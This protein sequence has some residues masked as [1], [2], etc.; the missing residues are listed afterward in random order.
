MESARILDGWCT[1]IGYHVAHGVWWARDERSALLGGGWGVGC[2]RSGAVRLASFPRY[3]DAHVVPDIEA[4]HLDASDHVLGIDAR[5][6]RLL[7]TKRKALQEAPAIITFI[8]RQ[9]PAGFVESDRT[10]I[11]VAAL[12]KERGSGILRGRDRRHTI[13]SK[14]GSRHD[15]A[16]GFD[17]ALIVPL[18]ESRWWVIA[19]CNGR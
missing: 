5:R 3:G 18:E 13:C 15:A 6:D 1:R 10:Q 2:G 7:D 16:S 8:F 19:W 17:E 4:A 11:T 14:W 9:V 12:E